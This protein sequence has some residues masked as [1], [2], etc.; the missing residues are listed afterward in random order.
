VAGRLVPA[1][2]R[3]S[4]IASAQTVVAVARMGAAAG[5]GALWFAVGPQKAMA[6]VAVALVL[7]VPF[8][9]MAVLRLERTAAG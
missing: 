6:G 4:G 3:A 1:H 8:A 5:F 2:V 7:V 9:L